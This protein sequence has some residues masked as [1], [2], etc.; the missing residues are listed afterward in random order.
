MQKLIEKISIS[1][2]KREFKHQATFNNRLKTTGGRYHIKNHNIDI[3]PKFIHHPQILIGIIK[4]E[5]CHYH[6]HLAGQSG[7]H[8][9]KEFKQLLNKVGGLRY[10]P[11]IDSP[12][13]KYIYECVKCHQKYYRQRKIN[14][15]LRCCGKCRG[16]II[17]KNIT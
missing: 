16:N 11:S 14:L 9:T 13:Y 10:V 5:L 7:R 17:F 4:H 12:K 15:K 8:S 3:N 2:F 6:L 1:E